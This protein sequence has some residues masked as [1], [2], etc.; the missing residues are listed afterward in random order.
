M[1]AIKGITQRQGLEKMRYVE[2]K[3]GDYARSRCFTTLDNFRKCYNP[4]ER[5]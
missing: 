4:L 3:E 1:R 2:V 5:L